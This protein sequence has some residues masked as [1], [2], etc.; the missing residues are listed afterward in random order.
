MSHFL[1]KLDTKSF[2]FN[3]K[4]D[5]DKVHTATVA[6]ILKQGRSISSALS[7]FEKCSSNVPLDCPNLIK[8]CIKNSKSIVN[9]NNLL[10]FNKIYLNG[11]FLTDEYEFCMYLKEETDPS[12]IQFGRIK[13]HYPSSLRYSDFRYNIDNRAIL[14]LISKKLNN[15]AFLVVK[16]EIFNEPGKINFITNIIGQNGIPYTKVFLNYKGDASKKFNQVFNEIADNYEIEAPLMREYGVPEILVIDPTTYK[17]AYDYCR[18][19]ALSFFLDKAEANGCTDIEVVSQN[20]PYDI[21]DIELLY[22]GRKKYIIL[23]F[24][25]TNQDYFFLS[26]AKNEFIYD[27]KG[28][29]VIVL[30]KSILTKSPKIE[31]FGVEELREMKRSLEVVKYSK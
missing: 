15:Y 26:N 28:D 21:I 14:N 1:F 17:V 16:V 29:A 3:I 22:K 25:T 31:V 18:S 20:Y 2:F 5:N 7:E 4:N 6:T 30:I 24:T 19:R 27:F 11:E 8:E 23:C 9:I 10:V 13:L 12:K